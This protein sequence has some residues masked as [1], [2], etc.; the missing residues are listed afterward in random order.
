PTLILGRVVNSLGNLVQFIKQGMT[1]TLSAG[2]PGPP[3]IAPTPYIAC[4]TNAQGDLHI[5]V[6]DAQRGLW[7]T[8]RRADGSWPQ[9]F[10]DVQAETSKAGP[11]IGPTPYVACA[12]NAQ[13]D[14]DICAI[15]AQG[16]LWHTIR[17]ADGSWPQAF[18]D[19]QAET[20]KVGPS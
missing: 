17:R 12:T 20:T 13:G 5:C 15:D 3:S 19:V 10:G 18:G 6:I 16:G 11:S 1:V 8:I 7:H 4:A 2:V 9:P 14:L